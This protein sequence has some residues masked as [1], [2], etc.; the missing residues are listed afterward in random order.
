MR[1]RGEVNMAAHVAAAAVRGVVGG[2]VKVKPQRE[3]GGNCCKTNLII[4]R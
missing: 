3:T 1:N 2:G 4:M